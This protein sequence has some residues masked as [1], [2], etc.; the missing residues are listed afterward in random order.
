MFSRVAK[1][2]G[3]LQESGENKGPE[4]PNADRS[5]SE[6]VVARRLAIRATFTRA[7]RNANFTLSWCSSR[8]VLKA[9]HGREQSTWQEHDNTCTR[10]RVESEIL[11]R[12]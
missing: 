4:V 7:E 6:L 2:P 1:F 12:G 10:V 5:S 9:I 11:E 3:L 8:V